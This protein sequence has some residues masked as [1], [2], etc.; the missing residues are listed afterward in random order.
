M[1][2][3]GFYEKEI[4][5]PLGGC[6]PGFAAR[7]EAVGVTSKL[8]A[9]AVALEADGKCIIMISIDS[10]HMIQSVHDTAVEI[11]EKHTG[12]ESRYVMISATHSHTAGPLNVRPGKYKQANY[13][14][15][16][17][18]TAMLGRLVGDCGVLAYQ[19]LE[20]MTAKFAKSDLHGVAFVR[21]YIMKDGNVRTNPGYQNPDI[22]RPVT[23]IDPEF[24]VF[25][26]YDEANRLRGIITNYA[27]HHCSVKLL[28]D[29]LGDRKYCADYSGVLSDELKREYGEDF[30]SV[31]I[32]G[33]C[34]NVNHIDV[35]LTWEEANAQPPFIKIGKIMAERVNQ[36]SKTAVPF[37]I[38]SVD[39]IKENAELR[40]REISEEDAA[41]YKY[42]IETM[43]LDG[44]NRSISNPETKEYKRTI[45]E[46][47]L[48]YADTPVVQ[49]HPIQ[50]LRFGE[51]MVYATPAEMYNDYG[52][53][54]KANSPSDINIIAELANGGMCCYI[55]SHEM[56]GYGA[57]E[58]Q[59]SSAP[60]EEDTGDKMA[61]LA[62]ELGKKIY[63]K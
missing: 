47:M 7:R 60:Y 25:Y 46:R 2:R 15:D 49:H 9:K 37:E 6:I 63:N 1:L 33:D 13:T 5:P 61:Q 11:I 48:N 50:A 51:C 54:M 28:N 56:F 8:Y 40:R 17:E 16:L 27:L 10:L 32:N 12:V 34:G 14:P 26:F 30:V 29:P 52:K 22:V 41:E 45:A 36:M 57:Y 38:N 59:P 24:P 18:Y 3:C 55:P 44:I 35:S 58:S 42:L 20:P 23:D 62:V 19:R 39:G 43:P 53:Y 4:T 31:F 21:N